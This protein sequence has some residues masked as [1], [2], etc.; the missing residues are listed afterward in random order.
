MTEVPGGRFVMGSNDFYPEERPVRQVEVDTFLIDAVP[1]TNAQFARFVAATGHVTCAER[2]PDPAG[3]PGTNPAMLVP[4]SLVFGP[5]PGAPA[6]PPA[7]HYCPGANWRHPQGPASGIAGLDDH[8]VVHVTYRDALAYARWAG[9]DLPTEA[10][11]EFACRAGRSDPRPY[12]WGD[13]LAPSGR[14][15]ANY[16]QGPFPDHNACLDGWEFTSMVRSFPPNALGLYDMIGNVWEWTQDSYSLPRRRAK[17]AEEGCCVVRNPRSADHV[18]GN[19]PSEHVKDRADKVVKGG[20]FLCA[21]NFCRRYRP[22][23]R[24]PQAV[25]TSS[26]HIGF[27]CVARAWSGRLG[28]S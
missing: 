27:R 23:A 10:E 4:G 6:A 7:W 3:Y 13:E 22:A 16:W 2:V 12:Q 21:E 1:V 17:G 19:G 5:V 20:S 28:V 15:M 11:W 9:K 25:D 18:P 8:P 24:Q 26:C 14:M